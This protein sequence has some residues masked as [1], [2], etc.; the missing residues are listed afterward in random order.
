MHKEIIPVSEYNNDGGSMIKI[1]I[2]ACFISIL[3]V[4]IAHAHPDSGFLPDAIAE[5]EYRIVIELDPND[6]ETRNKLGIVLYRKGKL[7]EA[8]DQ[9]KTVLKLEPG[10]FDAHDGTGLIMMKQQR[11]KDAITWFNRA[12]ALNNTDA[13]VYYHL[14]SAYKTTGETKKAITNYERSLSIKNNSIFLNELNFLK[15]KTR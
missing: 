15:A 5:T 1:T 4:D 10:N 6:I 11:Y 9:F 14:G 7:N 12:T 2:L 13:M 8:L 3:A